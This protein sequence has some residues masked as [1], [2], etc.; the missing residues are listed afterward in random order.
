LHKKIINKKY[1]SVDI[2]GDE[3]SRHFHY[4]WVCFSSGRCGLPH[5]DGPQ[6]TFGAA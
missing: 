1:Q 4:G 5:L 2:L 3:H 6:K